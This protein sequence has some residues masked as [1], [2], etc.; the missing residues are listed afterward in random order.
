MPTPQA[1][2]AP[3][4][5]ELRDANPRLPHRVKWIYFCTSESDFHGSVA[6]LVERGIHKPKVTGSIPVAAIEN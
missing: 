2:I 4:V 6:Q 1:A 3:G 5:K